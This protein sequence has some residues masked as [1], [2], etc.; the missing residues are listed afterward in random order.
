MSM[1][2]SPAI[3]SNDAVVFP[4]SY[5]CGQELQAVLEVVAESPREDPPV[6]PE[7]DLRFSLI[8]ALR[9]SIH[10]TLFGNMDASTIHIVHVSYLRSADGIIESRRG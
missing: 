2:G 8:H 3:Y 6:N 10:K 9:V 5:F 4:I 7:L 1:Q